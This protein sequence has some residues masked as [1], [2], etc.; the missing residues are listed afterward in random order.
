MAR[1]LTAAR[2]RYGEA[3]IKAL[4]FLCALLSVATAVPAPRFDSTVHDVR[5][6][7]LEA[8]PN[9]PVPAS[10][11]PPLAALYLIGAAGC[12][13]WLA[14]GQCLLLRMARRG[15]RPEPWLAELFDS[16]VASREV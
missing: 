3:V 14:A 11:V 12:L 1:R 13:A 9:S 6:P 2:P 4:L 16:L 7:S 10:T 8:A 15:R 5:H